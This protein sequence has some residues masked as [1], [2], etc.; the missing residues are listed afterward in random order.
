MQTNELFTLEHIMLL[1]ACALLV[2]QLVYLF[3][4]Y[5]RIARRRRA[6]EQAELHFSRE[7]PPL[8]VIICAHEE[9]EN[10]RNNLQSILEQDYPEYE[11][12]VINDGNT[13][14]SADFLTLMEERYRHLYHSFV[15]ESSRY[16]SR[17]KLALTLG[18]KASRYDWV[19]LTD[20]NCRPESNQWLRLMARNFTSCTDVVMGY[21]GYQRGK[22]WLHCRVAFDALF[23][24]MRYLGC[25]LAGMPYMAQGCNLAYRKEVF[26]KHKGFSSHLNLQRGDDDLFVNEVATAD[27]TRVETHPGALM[28]IEPVRRTKDWRE[29]KIGYMST[30]RFY[31]G[32]TRYLLGFETTSRMLFYVAWLVALALGLVTRQ[33]LV[34]AGAFACFL[35]RYI[36]QLIVFLHTCRVLGEPRR[37]YALLVVF[38]WLQPW[39]SLRWKLYCLLRKKSDFLRK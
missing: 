5:H 3:G 11:V 22:G 31:H 9:S 21:S 37:Y 38:D 29:K 35:V 1:G 16:I 13:D 25:A 15:P 14:E 34:A 19:V 17:K 32:F 2:V 8:S 39:Q 4:I 28:R 12:V 24:A 6:E 36:C 20:A 27:N 10:L 7:L 23:T 18:I 26:F 33:W 30:A